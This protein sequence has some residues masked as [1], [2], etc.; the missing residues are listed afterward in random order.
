MMDAE[1]PWQLLSAET[2]YDNPW[3]RVE[4]HEVVNPSG[5][6]SQY[7]KV[8]FKNRAVAILT[9]DAEDRTCLVGQFRYTLDEYSWELPMGGA[10][11]GEDPLEAARRE[12]RE[13]TGFIAASWTRL[14]LLHTSNSVTDESGVVYLA[15]GLGEGEPRPEETE[16]LTTLLMPFNEAVEWALSGRITDAISVAGILSMAAR[17][18]GASSEFQGTRA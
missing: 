3:I 9:L 16:A 1:N 10:P 15:Q 11:I 12:L 17:R 2:V 13:E 5:N 6:R 18:A 7:G 14:L 4:D 8:F